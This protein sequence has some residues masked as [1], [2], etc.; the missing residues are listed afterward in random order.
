VAVKP[1]NHGETQTAPTTKDLGYPSPRP[2]Q[3]LEGLSVEHELVHAEEN[4]IDRVRRRD[5][6]VPFLVGFDQGHQHVE[7]IVLRAA[8][9]RVPELLDLDQNSL[10]LLRISYGFDLHRYTVSTS[11]RSYS[12]CV[13][14]N[15]MKRILD[16]YLIATTKRYLFPPMLKTTRAL[17]TKLAF[18]EP[19]PE[20]CSES[21]WP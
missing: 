10:V 6:L 17:P 14:T 2:D 16:A 11:L 8:G 12:E 18:R 3:L 5:R 13:P 4:R 15:R 7:T 21:W 9:L 20:G 19:R 1:P